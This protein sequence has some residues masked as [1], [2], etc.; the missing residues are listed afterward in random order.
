[1][2]MFDSFYFAE[3]VLPDNREPNTV[4]FQSK[5][6]K[7][8]LNTFRVAADGSVQRFEWGDGEPEIYSN[9]EPINDAAI[10]YSY[11]GEYPNTQVQEYKILIHNS[12]LIHAEKLVERGYAT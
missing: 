8:E 9:P 12:K 2:G 11:Q 5:C 1:M 7:C 4:E 3:G 10:V 6:L